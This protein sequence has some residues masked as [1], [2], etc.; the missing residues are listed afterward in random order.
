[1]TSALVLNDHA[2]L[3]GAGQTADQVLDLFDWMGA[4]RTKLRI[5]DD[6][7]AS[8]PAGAPVAGKVAEGIE[9]ALT[10]RGPAFIAFGSRT[11]A[12]RHALATFL[13]ENGA[14]LPVVVHPSSPISPSARLG[15][16]VIVFAGC[17][18]GARAAVG[19]GSMVMNGVVIEH[20]VVIAE[21]CFLAPAATLSGF[22]AV[23][24][25]A[26]IGSGAVVS[27]EAKVGENTVVGAGAV[28]V[29]DAPARSV[30]TGVPAKVRGPLRDGMD[31]PS[32][33]ELQSLR[34]RQFRR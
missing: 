27:R 17:V 26:F 12:L 7:R 13:R 16:G 28:V 20:D 4:A 29:A 15:P 11:G 18:V 30:L 22:V 8:T 34:I 25:H 2:V 19:A 5:F 3:F 31:A 23:G 10:G 32:D 24:A 14:N 1:M 21:N 33:A 6:G 9:V